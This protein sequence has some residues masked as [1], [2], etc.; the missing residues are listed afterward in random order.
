MCAGAGSGAALWSAANQHHS[1]TNIDAF[2]SSLAPALTPLDTPSVLTVLPHNVDA[3][4]PIDGAAAVTNN[5]AASLAGDVTSLYQTQPQQQQQQ[6][7]FRSVTTCF[8]FA[9]KSSGGGA[10]FYR[11][12][13]LLRRAKRQAAAAAGGDDAADKD[14]K[15]AEDRCVSRYP[16]YCI[17]CRLRL[18]AQLQAKQHY[19]GRSHARRIRLLYG[20]PAVTAGTASDPAF[21]YTVNPSCDSE[22]SSVLLLLNNNNNNSSI[23]SEYLHGLPHK[24]FQGWPKLSTLQR[25][26]HFPAAELFGLSYFYLISQL[27]IVWGRKL[28][29]KRIEYHR[30][31]QPSTGLIDDGETYTHLYFAII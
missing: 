30:R 24:N 25:L 31:T 1:A 5:I 10:D 20:A 29:K 23:S 7:D 14:D 22:V 3:T 28:S 11:L 27:S 13:R 15:D 16:L 6:V 9:T 18:N 4:L 26:P 17:V 19:T 8:R 21:S 12:R 2:S